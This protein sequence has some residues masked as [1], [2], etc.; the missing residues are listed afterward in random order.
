M[1]QI[2]QGLGQRIQLQAGLGAAKDEGSAW[3]PRAGVRLVR[4]L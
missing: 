1:P 3:R 4:Q 2:Q